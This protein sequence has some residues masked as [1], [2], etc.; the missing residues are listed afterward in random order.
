[1][2]RAIICDDESDVFSIIEYFIKEEG[3]PIE[4]VATAKDGREALDLIQKEKP[5][6]VFI[7]IQMPY[8]NGLEVIEKTKDCKFIIITAYGSFEYAQKALRL[9]ACDIISK[10]IDLEQLKEAISRTVEWE[11]TGNET[12]DNILLYIHKNYNQHIELDEMAEQCH[13]SKVHVSRIFKKVMGETVFSYVHKVRI[14]QAKY[15]LLN[16]KDAINAISE[17]VGYQ[18]LHNFYHYFKK[19]TGMTPASFI[20]KET[21]REK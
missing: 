14:E 7:D 15:L 10:P 21:L 19:Y 6:I 11:F 20:K 18:S 9:G 16:K 3:F 13:V 17:M 1:M 4:I 5:D 8:M 12:V 2:I